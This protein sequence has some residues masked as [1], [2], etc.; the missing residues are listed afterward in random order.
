MAISWK[1]L[2]MTAVLAI[3]A[4]GIGA[5]ATSTW[6]NA[7]DTA[8]SLHDIVHEDLDLSAEQLERIEAIEVR[9]SER[10]QTLESEVNQ[11]NRELAN[12]IETADG[13]SRRVQPSVNH[14]HDAMGDLQQATISH[15]F[16]MRSVMTTQQATRFDQSLV[17]ALTTDGAQAD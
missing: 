1:S 16:E 12:A 7:R 15:I 2:A 6:M 17:K 11:A 3:L 9:F 13:D 10:R 8:P 14:F 4:G 5:W